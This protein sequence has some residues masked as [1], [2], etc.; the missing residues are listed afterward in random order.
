MGF[1]NCINNSCGGGGA[2]SSPPIRLLS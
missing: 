1:V 2:I